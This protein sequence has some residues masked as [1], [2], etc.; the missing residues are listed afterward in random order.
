M[1][2]KRIYLD[3]AATTKIDEEVLAEMLPF[4]KNKF[5]NASS[6]HYFGQKSSAGVDWARD[7]VAKFLGCDTDEVLFTSGATE[8]NNL[9]IQ[10]LVDYIWL[11]KKQMPHIIVS[12]I[13]HSAVLETAK[14]LEKQGRAEVTWLKADKNG[15]VREKDL[16]DLIKEN[17]ALV[18]VMYVNNEIGTIQPI[19]EIGKILKNLNETRKGNK[20]YFHTDAVQAIN[21]LPCAVDY[22]QVDLLSLSAH[23]FYGPKGVGV[24]YKRKGTTI[25][26]QVFGGHHEFNFRPGTLNTPGVVGLAK[27]LELVSGNQKKENDRLAYLKGKLIKL[28][29]EQIPN[30]S[31]N[32]HETRS[33]PSCI[34]LSFPGSEGES[35]LM[36][37]D[38]EGI[39][40]S[41]GSAC[42]SGALDPSHVLTAIGLP[43]EV[44]HSSIR[45]SLG[46][47]NTEKDIKE[48]VRILKPIIERL[49][50]MSPIK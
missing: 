44:S 17:T 14:N 16:K 25:T 5:G 23:K 9:A 8:S 37:L 49:R 24:L 13:E 33:I 34:N 42:A 46:R 38:M 18:S 35:I 1:L 30:V 48:F 40:V 10:G 19:K 41:T 15:I 50:E 22:L 12:N 31:L 27:A 28:V 36:M 45:V 4:L 11:H 3:H 7:I 20:I 29:N 39:A 6:M 43:P 26:P 47:E 32:G 21:Y 2:N